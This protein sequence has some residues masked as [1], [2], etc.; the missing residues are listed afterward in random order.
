MAYFNS[1]FSSQTDWRRSV[2]VGALVLG[3][4]L[5]LAFAFGAAPVGAD[6]DPPACTGAG[7]TLNFDVYSDAGGTIP[8]TS[9]TQGQ[10][11]YY[12]ATLE[13]AGGANCNFGGEAGDELSVTLPDGSAALGS[14]FAVPLVEDLNPFETPLLSYVVDSADVGTNGAPADHVRSSASFDATSH[15]TPHQAIGG[16]SNLDTPFEQ[17]IPEVTT[18]VHNESHEDVTDA[19]VPQGEDVHDMVTVA[20]TQ[21]G[22]VPT[23]TVD[24]AL[25]DGL[26]CQDGDPT[27]ESGVALDGSGEAE[28]APF[29]PGVGEYSYSVHYDGDE[30]YTEG[31]AECEPF[32]VVAPL[33]VSKT[34][35]TSYDRDWDWTI[36]KTGATTTLLL[37]EGESYTVD[38]EVTVDATS[39]DINHSVTGTITVTNPLG[40]T[41]AEVTAVDDVLNVS[42]A[43]NVSC[44]DEDGDTTAPW[45][46]SA[47]EVLT[48]TYEQLSAS[49]TDSGNTATVTTSG[50]VPGGEDT[51]PVSFGDPTNET[52]ECVTVNDDSV[53][54]PQG[55]VI[56]EGDADKTIEYSVTFGP[57]QDG[58]DV[59]LECG[60]NLHRNVANFVTS[61]QDQEGDDVGENDWLVTINVECE[62]GCTLTQ[63]YWKTHN[64]SFHGGAPTDDNW[65]NVTP[66]AE[67]SGFFTAVNS[68]PVVGP[69]DIAAPFTWFSVFWTPPAG[70]PYYNLAH[71]Y[72]AAKLNILNGASAP[73]EVTDAITAAEGFFDDRTSDSVGKGKN[74]KADRPLLTGLAGTLGSYNEGDI[75]PGH[76]DEQI[77]E[78]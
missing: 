74:A 42:G 71:Q 44:E 67:L 12:Q 17:L 78:A 43:A 19:V 72:M 3:L 1:F 25:H 13:W 64:E 75:G 23:G 38:Y 7:F 28:S 37:A 26:L 21:E 46:L 16:N 45:T 49:P 6:Q 14:P 31:I 48:C 54:G 34:V 36:D 56:C 4:G 55:V 5:A 76:C 61:D 57:D 53:N 20:G 40:N 15:R 39:E 41:D 68:F 2:L 9:V 24:F 69:N 35:E 73:T 8:A 60:E 29:T 33:I 51:Q 10:T 52:D 32:T 18:E 70:N 63:G 59:I 77:P 66:L 22:G 65:D 50:D 62:T 11:I 30:N 47:G 27:V 58:T